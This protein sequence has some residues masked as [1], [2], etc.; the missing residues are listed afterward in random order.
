VYQ[1]TTVL[2]GNEY[3][4]FWKIISDTLQIFSVNDYQVMVRD[5]AITV[6]DDDE[7]IGVWLS[8]TAGTSYDNS[9]KYEYK[10]N[11]TLVVSNPNG[12]EI[13]KKEIRRDVDGYYEIVVNGNLVSGICYFINGKRLYLYQAKIDC[14]DVTGEC[15]NEERIIFHRAKD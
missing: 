3:H 14:N 9:I 4:Y 1:Y 13:D 7:L 6:R 2:R 10:T 5:S 12:D 8:N 15:K 11:Y